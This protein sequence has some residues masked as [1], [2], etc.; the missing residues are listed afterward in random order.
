[1]LEEHHSWSHII[2]AGG[3]DGG[4]RLGMEK[5]L[6]GTNGGNNVITLINC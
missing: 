6:G 2:I 5:G 3:G 4:A 1:M